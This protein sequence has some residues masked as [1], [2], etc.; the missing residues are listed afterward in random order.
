MGYSVKDHIKVADVI[1]LSVDTV[2]DH[3]TDAKYVIIQSDNA[4]GF[5]S[6]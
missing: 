5:D 4:S 3:H 2:Q 1:Q 6:Q